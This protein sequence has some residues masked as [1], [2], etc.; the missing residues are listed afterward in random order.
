MLLKW[1]AGTALTVGLVAGAHAQNF[2]T[3]PMRLV[4]PFPPGGP[5]DMLGRAMAQKLGE[6]MGQSMVADNRPGAGGNLGIEL[7]AKAPPDGHTIV[8]AA[9]GLAIAPSLYSKLNYEQKDL[10]PIS[11]VAEM[12]NVVLVHPSVPAKNFKEF[13]QLVSKYPG[14]LNYGSGGV[15][16]TTHITP[17]LMMN[18]TGGKMTHV[19]YKG[20][21]L[22]LISLMSGQIDVLIMTVAASHAQVNAG[23]V[24]ALAVMAPERAAQLPDVPNLKELGH[25]NFIVRLWYG[26]LAPAGTAEPLIARLNAEIHKAW[27]AP[28]LRGRLTGAGIVPFLS[29]PQEFANFIQTE[30]V[31]YAKVIKSANIRVD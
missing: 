18:L 7:A 21:G 9:S 2:P 13:L 28:D 12:R 22:A 10:A 30:T 26:M 16:T 31:R 20:S 19:P 3:K 4:L 24:R 11:L 27:A 17:E 29:T 5:T 25:E 15:G 8:L 1:L 6:Q 14:R 23:K